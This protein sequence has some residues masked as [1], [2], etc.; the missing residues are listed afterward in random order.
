MKLDS[1]ASRPLLPIPLSV[2]LTL[3]WVGL[4]RLFFLWVTAQA[5]AAHDGRVWAA[6]LFNERVL[7]SARLP[8][9]IVALSLL[10]LIYLWLDYR[11]RPEH[12]LRTVVFLVAAG[13]LVYLSWAVWHSW[14]SRLALP[15]PPGDM[16]MTALPA[17]LARLAAG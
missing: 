13:L 6:R 7:G 8:T 9:I 17:N 2:L 10:L 5:S 1:R 3:L 14:W 12:G 15:I 11:S 4:V 16:L